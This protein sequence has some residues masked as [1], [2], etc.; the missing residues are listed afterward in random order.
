MKRLIYLTSL[1]FFAVV[2]YSCQGPAGNKV[3]TKDAQEVTEKA[4]QGD[5]AVADVSRSMIEWLGTKPT[6]EHTGN[7][8]LSE[9][10][11]FLNDGQVSGGNFTVDMSSIENYDLEDPEYNQKLVDHLKSADFFDVEKYPV[12][13]FTIT[14]IVSIDPS[15]VKTEDFRPTHRITGNLTMKD[16]TKS[17]SFDAVVVVHEDEV[18]AYTPQFFINRADWNVQYGSRSFFDDLKDKFIYD[19]IGMS[20]KLYANR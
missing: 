5:V 12:A 11:L 14:E 16:I 9:G 19:D 10:E 20:I 17:I 7:I 13:V 4:T 8:K 1:V 3:E 6:G 18:V 15:E 2:I